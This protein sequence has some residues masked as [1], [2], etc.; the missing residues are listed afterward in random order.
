M[1]IHILQHETKGQTPYATAATDSIIQTWQWPALRQTSQ[2]PHRVR[3]LTRH[4][5]EPQ[6]SDRRLYGSTHVVVCSLSFLTLQASISS[7]ICQTSLPLNVPSDLQSMPMTLAVALTV[8]LSSK[9]SSLI[10]GPIPACLL[11]SYR[12]NGMTSSTC[13][14][15]TRSSRLAAVARSGGRVTNVQT[16]YH[17]SGRLL[18]MTG[19]MEGAVLS[20]QATPFVSIT[21]LPER[22]L[23]LRCFGM[24]RRT[25]PCHQTC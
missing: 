21:R 12:N 1:L 24:P 23:K 2:V 19:R 18:L 25:T 8:C 16:A 20:A 7:L 10:R 22:H 3:R 4:A 11:T 5:Q 9:A 13:T 17:T 14:L 15:A 6:K